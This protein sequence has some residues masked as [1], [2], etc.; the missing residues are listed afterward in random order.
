MHC[1]DLWLKTEKRK[2]KQGWK[3]RVEGLDGGEKNKKLAQDDL[4][5]KKRKLQIEKN[6]T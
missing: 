5:K 2:A 4:V 6:T 1:M 3:E